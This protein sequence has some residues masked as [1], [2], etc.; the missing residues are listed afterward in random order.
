[1][2]D[3]LCECGCGTPTNTAPQTHRKKGLIKGQPMRFARGHRI[4]REPTVP[5]PNPSGLCMCGCGH[6]TN[7]AKVTNGGL[8]HRNGHP[9]PFL[10]GHHNRNRPELFWTHVRKGDGCWEWVVLA[11]RPVTARCAGTDGRFLLT[12]GRMRWPTAPSHP[13]CSFA[14]AA[15]TSHA[16]APTTCSSAHRTTTSRIWWP[17]GSTSEANASRDR[18]SQRPTCWRFGEGWQ[19][20]SGRATSLAGMASIPQRSPT[21]RLDGR[22]RGCVTLPSEESATLLCRPGTSCSV[23]FADR[24]GARRS[25]CRRTWSR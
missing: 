20:G 2:S 9:V 14:I 19:Q 1:M 13:G 3:H 17:R 8:G 18:G 15:T 22:G 24:F 6:P 11:S 10:K 4:R 21:S 25:A 16:Y 7:V 12:D 23:G 5:A